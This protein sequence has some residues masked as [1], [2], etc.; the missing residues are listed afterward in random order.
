MDQK[1]FCLGMEL[2]D[3]PID[4][5]KCTDKE[6]VVD[7]LRAIHMKGVLHKDIR[8]ENILSRKDGGYSIIDFAFAE[9][10]SIWNSFPFENY[11]MWIWHRNFENKELLVFISPTKYEPDVNWILESCELD[12]RDRTNVTVNGVYVTDRPI[13]S[14]QGQPPQ[15]LRTMDF[16]NRNRYDDAPPNDPSHSGRITCPH[17]RGMGVIQKTKLSS[18]QIRKIEANETGE[19][20]K[21]PSLLDLPP[22][23]PL[24]KSGDKYDNLP[25]LDDEFGKKKKRKKQRANR[26]K[27]FGPGLSNDYPPFARQPRSLMSDRVIPPMRGPSAA[28]YMH[29]GSNKR[30]WGPN[31]ANMPER[32]DG[33]E[34]SNV[35][36][37]SL[38]VLYSNYLK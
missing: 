4:V 38:G 10:N 12:R 13:I 25:G 6:G 19:T 21:P 29:Q 16:D 8:K 28:G 9:R 7:S 24:A 3:S 30:P 27:N 33:K 37:F 20:P 2:L 14:K 26:M 35:D 31:F 5:V 22:S 18:G 23:A 34:L 36:I 32:N 11:P 15:P 17:C 1:H